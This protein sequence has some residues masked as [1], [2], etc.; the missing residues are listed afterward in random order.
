MPISKE[1]VHLQP[2][3]MSSVHPT[4]IDRGSLKRQQSSGSLILLDTL[5]YPTSLNWILDSS[6]RNWQ[7]NLSRI[8]K[9]KQ[10]LRI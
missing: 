10:E 3:E 2:S 5:L 4:G 9:C 7:K 6:G 1:L 8:E